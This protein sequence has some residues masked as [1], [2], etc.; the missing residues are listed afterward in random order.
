M[1]KGLNELRMR[2]EYEQGNVQEKRERATEREFLEWMEKRER[3]MERE[4]LEWMY[5]HTRENEMG[6]GLQEKRERATEREFLEWMYC[7]SDFGPA[8]DDVRNEMKKRF[9]KETGKNIPIGY[10]EG[11]DGET[12][13]DKD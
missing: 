1:E 3:A 13:M 9:M 11:P 8:D 5:C 10:N 2:F 7:E 4:F 6:K 12:P